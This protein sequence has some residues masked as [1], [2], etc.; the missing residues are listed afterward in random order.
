MSVHIST[1]DWE[2]ALQTAKKCGVDN[3]SPFDLLAI[4][5]GTEAPPTSQLA[6][7]YGVRLKILKAWQD[8]VA[9]LNMTT[10]QQSDEEWSFDDVVS[11]KSPSGFKFITTSHS[12]DDNGVTRSFSTLDSA[13]EAL[14]RTL[15]HNRTPKKISKDLSSRFK[16]KGQKRTRQDAKRKRGSESTLAPTRNGSVRTV[17]LD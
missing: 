14:L 4:V 6:E 1:C 8:R 2:S 13:V 11:N 3:P 10:W 15:N 9:A 12:F 16:E 5:A 17:L 7:K